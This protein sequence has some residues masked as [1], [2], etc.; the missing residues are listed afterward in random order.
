MRLF[1]QALADAGKRVLIW[2]RPNTG[3]S[4]IQLYGETES[5]MRADTLAAVVEE[6]GIGT[7]SALGGSGGARDSIVFAIRH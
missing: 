6:L 4:D 2:D 1:A 3:R 5:H 7:V